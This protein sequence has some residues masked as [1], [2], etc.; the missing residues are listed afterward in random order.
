VW[1]AETGALLATF[2]GHTDWVVSSA[3]VG[4][5]GG[6]VV[7]ASTDGTARVWD[8]L[9][10]PELDELAQLAAPVTDVAYAEDGPVV[11]AVAGD[12]RMHVLDAATGSELGVEPGKPRSR[13]VTGPGGETATIRGNTVVVRAGEGKIVLRGHRDRVTSTAFSAAGTLVVTASRDHDARI[14]DASTGDTIR[15]LSGHFGVVNDARFSPDARWVVTGAPASAGLW[16]ARSGTL[17][18]Y[19]RGHKGPVLS[20]GFDPAGRTIVTG[21]VDGTVRT[22]RCEICDELDELVELARSRLAQTGR[23]LSAAERERY[24]G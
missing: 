23:E 22:Y 24:L 14:W 17:V 15:V 6:S 2:A 1:K 21:G 4:R 16:D 11:R 12:G 5:T 7:T 18:T 19:L 10:Q 3:F 20:A 8:A 13:K 9:V